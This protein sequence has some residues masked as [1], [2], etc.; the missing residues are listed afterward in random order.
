MRLTRFLP[1]ATL[2]AVFWC[3]PAAAQSTYDIGVLTG[4]LKTSSAGAL[5]FHVGPNYEVTFARRLWRGDAASVAVEI[6]F[7]AQN[8]ISTKTPG[9][10]LPREYASFFLTPGVRIHAHPDRA[11][12]VFGT[13]G[14]GYARYSESKLRED[15]GPNPQQRDTNSG[16]VQFGA[17][18]DVRGGSWLALR[19][20][21]RDIVTGARQ[22]SIATPDDMVH[23]IVIAL[24]AAIRF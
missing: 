4:W 14:G 17:G 15:G 9:A 7:F 23:N 13:V 2:A 8:S 6:P 22:F 5:T 24:G 10:L 19:G 18:I 3:G 11:V 12:S 1:A 16:A 20:E 21:V